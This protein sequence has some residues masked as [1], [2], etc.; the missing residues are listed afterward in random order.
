[1]RQHP[2]LPFSIYYLCNSSVL[3]THAHFMQSLVPL[4]VTC[5][6]QILELPGSVSQLLVHSSLLPDAWQQ[7]SGALRSPTGLPLLPPALPL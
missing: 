2:L 3:L 6:S 7:R 4:E 1:M 5:P